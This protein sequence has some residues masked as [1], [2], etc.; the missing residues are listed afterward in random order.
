[1]RIFIIALPLLAAV[2]LIVRAI[3]KSSVRS[4]C[5]ASTEGRLVNVDNGVEASSVG[6]GTTVCNTVYYPVYEYVIDGMAYW[7]QL[8]IHSPNPDAFEKSVSVLYNPARYDMCYINGLQG[9][10]VSTYDKDEYDK[11]SGGKNLTSDY[12]WRP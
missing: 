10:I 3:V 1:M 6:M 9:K 12:K 11:N 4:Q 8:D 5:T 2:I 7:A